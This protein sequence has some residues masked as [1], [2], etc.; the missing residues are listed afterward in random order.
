MMTTIIRRVSIA[1][2]LVCSLQLCQAQAPNGDFSFTFGPPKTSVFDLSGDYK[3]TQPTLVN[4]VEGATL[5]FG[6]SVLEDA[7]G[8]LTGSGTTVL[9]VGNGNFV[10]AEY[11]VTG[12]VSRGGPRPP[13]VN[14][15]IRLRGDDTVAGV[16]TPFSITISYNLDINPETQTFTGKSRGSARFT[17]LGTALIRSD[18]TPPIPLLA[19]AGN[20]S[21]AANLN[22]VALKRLGG[23]G[24]IVLSNGRILPVNVS[25]NYSPASG[26]ARL[27]LTGINEAR[28]TTLSITF[29]QGAQE[30]IIER[31]TGRV[32]GLTVRE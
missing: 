24:S 6:V 5:S 23:S 25:G 15:L 18:D 14:L 26:R 9:E 20:G 28:G 12:V 11:R 32:L 8:R 3:I 21:F 29:F 2:L 1:A 19:S 31:V 16:S 4:G 27:L 10:A 7:R 30:I 17:K 22:I 13:H